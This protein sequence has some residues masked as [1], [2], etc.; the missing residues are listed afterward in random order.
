MRFSER[1]GYKP[2]RDIIQKESIDD[3][4]KN[5]LWSVFHSYIW[6]RIEH[7]HNQSSFTRNSN[8]YS[9]VESYWLNL[10]KNPTDTIPQWTSDSLKIIRDYF[11]N[12]AWHEIY[13]LIEE[14]IEHY[15]YQRVSNKDSFITNINNMLEREN[16]AY[17]IINDEIIPI[18]SEQEIQSIETALENTNQY[19]GV[20]QHLNQALKLMSDRQKPDYRNSIKESVSALEGMCQKIL[21]KDKV[22]LGDAIGQIEKQYPI[23]PALKASIKSLYGYTSDA[24]GIRH[25]M[26][27]ESNLS[28]IDAKFMLV[29]CTNFINYLIDKTRDQRWSHLFEQL[30]AYL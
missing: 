3:A 16:S 23:H 6:N 18:T 15:P 28:Y 17:R 13:S 11:F 4:L 26:L 29:A 10:F 9:L 8:I 24:D 14:T 2:V 25:A 7:G 21:K 19:L 12:C 22:T 27:D 1:Y 30:K 5:G 20:Q